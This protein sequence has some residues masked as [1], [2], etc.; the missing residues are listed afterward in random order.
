MEMQGT[1]E[2]VFGKKPK[3]GGKALKVADSVTNVFDVTVGTGGKRKP[4]DPGTVDV[5]SDVR[6]VIHPQG[7]R[8]KKDKDKK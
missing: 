1:V 6:K 5:G 2:K 4:K 3:K 8:P 7:K